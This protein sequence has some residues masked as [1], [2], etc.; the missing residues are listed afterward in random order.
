MPIKAIRINSNFLFI[1]IENL[2]LVCITTVF[3]KI[4]KSTINDNQRNKQKGDT[5]RYHL[6]YLFK[7]NIIYE[8]LLRKVFE[9]T[10]NIQHPFYP[11]GYALLRKVCPRYKKRPWLHQ[12]RGLPSCILHPSTPV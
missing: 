2:V 11:N 8:F 10:L 3:S 1:I 12:I 7:R 9:W 6:L 4:L 5:L